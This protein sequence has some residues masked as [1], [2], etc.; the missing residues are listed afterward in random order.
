MKFEELFEA[1]MDELNKEHPIEESIGLGLATVGLGALAWGFIRKRI[2]EL[3]EVKV[4]NAFFDEADPNRKIERMIEDVFK[5]FRLVNSLTD[6]DRMESEIDKVNNRLEYLKRQAKDFDVN[7]VKQQK[8][9]GRGDTNVDMAS[10]NKVFAL[11]PEKEKKRLEKAI[12]KFVDTVTATFEREVE[13]KKNELY[14]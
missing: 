3:R 8:S 5:K 1:K 2:Q 6:L 9:F 12:N 14:A 13:E 4:V 11:N 7:N 10:G